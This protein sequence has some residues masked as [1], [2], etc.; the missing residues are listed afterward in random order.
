MKR[1]GIL[2]K[3][4]CLSLLSLSV[5]TT[6][7]TA[8]S[9][10]DNEFNEKVRNYL[11]NNPEIILEAMELLGEREAERQMAERVAPVYKE[12]VTTD[13]DLVIGNKDAKIKLIEFF[14][15]RCAVCKSVVPTLESFVEAN[16]DVAVIKKHLPILTPS[17]ERASRYVLATNMIYGSESYGQMHKALYATRRPLNE[18]TFEKVSGELNLDH[19]KIME[20]YDADEITQIIDTNRDIAIELEIRGTPAFLTATKLK[21]GNVDLKNLSELSEIAN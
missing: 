18:A 1:A 19:T 13:T 15:Y 7:L 10:T 12:L 14:D 8:Q 16:P 11:L 5:S 4:A 6:T 9:L 17:S 2:A 3:T 20:K 21:I